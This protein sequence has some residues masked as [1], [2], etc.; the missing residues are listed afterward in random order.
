ML[1]LFFA[2]LPLGG[3][4]KGVA[5]PRK[6]FIVRSSRGQQDLFRLPLYRG[7]VKRFTRDAKAE[8][9]LQCHTQKLIYTAGTGIYWQPTKGGKERQLGTLPMGLYAA[10]GGRLRRFIGVSPLGTHLFWPQEVSLA[11]ADFAGT[12]RRTI[13]PPKGRSLVH[14]AHWHPAGGEL[15]YQTYDKT[16][17]RLLFHFRALSAATDRLI[18]SPLGVGIKGVLSFE[19]Y[20]SRD[21]LF[22]AVNL[23]AVV[24]TKKGGR[25]RFFVIMDVGS[26]TVVKLP[27][28]YGIKRFH[29]F[30]K[31]GRLLF[32]AGWGK[33][34]ALYRFTPS[35]R[36]LRRIERIGVEEV[37]GFFPQ[38]DVFVV[39]QVVKCAKPRLTSIKLWGKRRRLLRWAKWTEVLAMDPTR[40]WGIFRA[41]SQCRTSRP[42]LYLMRMDG[43]LLLRELPKRRFRVLRHLSPSKIA[44]CK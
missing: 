23:D 43:T 36:V 21:G 13:S 32:T 40:T 4:L 5:R 3:S 24:R 31:R 8:D 1:Y 25:R 35:S 17:G 15:F 39:N 12:F 29:G 27:K 19:S 9:N 28:G 6:I 41:G 10:Y 18:V 37:Y 26:G 34:K 16:T 30:D 14:P 11:L 7:R 33:R 44:L 42:N 22:L 2:L 38:R 20:W